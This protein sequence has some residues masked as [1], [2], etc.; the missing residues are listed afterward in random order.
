MDAKRMV[1][2]ARARL[3]QDNVFFGS[4]ALRLAMKETTKIKR[5]KTNGKWIKYNP[6]YVAELS[7][8]E[9]VGVVCHEVMHCVLQHVGKLRRGSRTAKKW[10]V[11]CDYVANQLIVDAGMELPIGA[12]LDPR[13]I[14]MGAEEVY[15]IW[16]NYRFPVLNSVV[17]HLGVPPCYFYSEVTTVFRLKKKGAGNSGP[18]LCRV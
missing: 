15:N 3:I 6:E 5:L 12:L 10:N 14:G 8:P 11:A 7:M 4:L 16:P 18:L 13:F 2:K 17:N 9:L 1:T